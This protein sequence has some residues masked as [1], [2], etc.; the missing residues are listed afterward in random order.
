VESV[1][2]FKFF[3]IVS[4]AHVPA[5]FAA[6]MKNKQKRGQCNDDILIVLAINDSSVG[7]K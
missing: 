1:K 5:I 7:K 3:Q 6:E 4:G 2:T